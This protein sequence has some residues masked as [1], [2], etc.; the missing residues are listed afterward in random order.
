ML[1]PRLFAAAVALGGAVACGPSPLGPP[2]DKWAVDPLTWL[3]QCSAQV[4][5]SAYG[6]KQLPTSWDAVRLDADVGSLVV[7]GDTS[8]PGVVVITLCDFGGDEGAACSETSVDDDTHVESFG[9]NSAIVLVPPTIDVE[10][11]TVTGALCV[12]R[13]TGSV[14][15][16]NHRGGGTTVHADL[17]AGAPVEA[18]TTRG[19]IRVTLSEGQAA[20]LDVETEAADAIIVDE[21]P[22]DGEQDATSMFG[23]LGAGEP[24][25]DVTLRALQTGTVTL[26]AR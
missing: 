5:T 25:A 26:E 6:V 3:R 23:V 10:L 16:T 13:V 12:E 22:F 19:E 8:N 11:T 7:V 2:P 20:N 1:R 21:L 9:A 24:L 15:L 4:D 18:T 17:S 14:A